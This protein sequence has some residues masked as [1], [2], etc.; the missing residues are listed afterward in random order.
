MRKY[1]LLSVATLMMSG[2]A[3]AVAPE[4][5]ITT[6]ATGT[7]EVNASILRNATVS[8]TPVN[9]GTIAVP[10]NNEVATI[11]MSSDGSG[12][13]T[14]EIQGDNIVHLGDNS[15]GYCDGINDFDP[16]MIEREG[17]DTTVLI[18]NENGD[19]LSFEPVANGRGYIAGT[20]RIPSSVTIGTYS[21]SFTITTTY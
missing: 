9:F 7:V 20:L 18:S 11:T 8:C 14:I 21:G 19:T 5:P 16:D 2:T 1:F 13:T 10:E 15:A 17:K 6:Y 4:E 12:R 3:N